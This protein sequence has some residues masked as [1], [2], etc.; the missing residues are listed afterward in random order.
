VNV[1]AFEDVFVP[2]EQLLYQ[3]AGLRPAQVARI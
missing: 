3:D 1:E 2:E